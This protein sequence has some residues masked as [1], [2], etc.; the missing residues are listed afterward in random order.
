MKF[1]DVIVP[2]KYDSDRDGVPVQKTAWNRVGRAWKTRA[3]DSMLLELYLMPNQTYLISFKER[4]TAPP[5]PSRD[6]LP[7]FE[8][9]AE[10]KVVAHE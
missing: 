1:Y 4:P 7:D 6:S 8:S 2:K 9:F 3:G 5:E 10:D